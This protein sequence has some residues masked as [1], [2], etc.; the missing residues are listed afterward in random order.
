[1]TWPTHPIR[2]FKARRQLAIEYSCYRSK[3]IPE[4]PWHWLVRRDEIVVRPS[5]A[6]EE[7]A[8]ILLWTWW[9]PLLR[10]NMRSLTDR[11]NVPLIDSKSR[12]IPD[13]VVA[14]K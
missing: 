5:I 11:S 14:K 12:D 10:V 6:A 1:M 7:D 8:P 2:P 13:G 3:P 4:V 9:W